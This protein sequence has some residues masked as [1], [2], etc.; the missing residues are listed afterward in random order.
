MKSML[1]SAM[2]LPAIAASLLV[3]CHLES[4]QRLLV[5]LGLD[6]Q[7]L[8]ELPP[9]ERTLACVAETDGTTLASF[10]DEHATSLTAFQRDPDR[11]DWSGLICLTLSSQAQAEQIKQT[12]DV[13]EVA[14]AA[15][16]DRRHDPLLGF[17]SLLRQRYDTLTWHAEEN[18][19][20]QAEK[21]QLQSNHEQRLAESRRL[22]TEQE[23]QIQALELQVRKLKE[24]EQMLQPQSIE[25]R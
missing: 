14:V 17:L 19:Y 22:A 21:Q 11:G 8:A 15:R 24:V 12:I 18:S 7:S 23:K 3:G 6:T 5:E 25:P 4:G 20:W 10:R 9:P 16:G 13:I 2:L 1:K